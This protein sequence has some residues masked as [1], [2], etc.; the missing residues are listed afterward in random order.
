M[1][2]VLRDSNQGPFLTKVLGYGQAEGLLT[3]TQLGQIKSK[4]VLMSLKLADKFYNKHKMH[5]LEN[6][7]YDVIG[8][9][10]LGLMSLSNHDLAQALKLLLTPNGIVTA[11][12]KG[13]SM[14]SSVSKYKLNGKSVYG[15]IDPTLL[16]KVST[17][18]DA[19]E[20]Q[21][22][23]GYQDALLDFNR[24]ESIVC[25]LQ[26]FYAR[27]TYDP[28]DCLSLENV[29]A[30]VVLYRLFFG[31][32]KVRFDLKQRLAK[33]ELEDEW[34]STEHIEQ[35]IQLTLSEMPTQLAD[36]IKIDQGK[37]FTAGLLRTLT[38]AKN[39]RDLRLTDASPERLERYEYKEGLTGLLGWPV[40]ISL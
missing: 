21:G 32:V 31:P 24:E 20:W 15:D 37:Y 11:F 8:V 30:E 14:L 28:L 34:F 39:Y 16:D 38:F 19:D 25:L 9:A 18:S 36:T 22:W 23:Q 40:Y 6:A 1:Q 35:Q 7:A 2:I 10:S 13:W 4:A 29:F 33:I 27:T 12:Q 3:E 17:P 5:L 26:Q